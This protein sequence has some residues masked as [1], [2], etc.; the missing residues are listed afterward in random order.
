ASLPT[1][2][3]ALF[4]YNH[5]FKYN[6]RMG[7]KLSSQE[8]E[9]TA[10]KVRK[11]YND[12]IISYMLTPRIKEGFE[13]RYNEIK[14]YGFDPTRFFNDE[15]KALIE[16]EQKEKEKINNAGKSININL[17]KNINKET[18][19]KDF[20]DK[21]LEQLLEKIEKYPSLFIHPNANKEIEKLFGA[22]IDF[23]KGMWKTYEDIA[24]KYRINKYDLTHIKLEKMLNNFTRVYSGNVTIRLLQYKD[25]LNSRVSLTKNIDKEEKLCIF[26][27]ASL[28]RMFI[29][30]I[31][32]LINYPGILES[33]KDKLLKLIKHLDVMIDDF[34]LKDL[35][36]LGSRK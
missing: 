17:N 28:I 14:K 31:S 22:L 12:L 9:S 24:K 7:K 29:E 20:A 23:D 25:M 6:N 21:I 32:G 3:A 26:E 33:E 30:I 5:Y 11:K 35:M 19:K 27:C 13:E 4:T 2:Y 18:D 36:M 1:G 10:E 15:I 8:I 16:L 34:R